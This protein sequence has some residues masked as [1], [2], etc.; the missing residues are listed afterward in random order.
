MHC[1]AHPHTDPQFRVAVDPEAA[2]E[3][4][5]DSAQPVRLEV[6]FPPSYPDE[7]PK[8]VVKFSHIVNRSFPLYRQPPCRVPLTR[9]TSRSQLPRHAEA[10]TKHL[11]A[12]AENLKGQVMIFMLVTA[13]KEWLETNDLSTAKVQP[14]SQ[15]VSQ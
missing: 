7:V 2:E 8:I 12:E 15:Q 5:G 3:R 9:T 14:P 11:V 4:E 6:T 10:L 1:T 13:A